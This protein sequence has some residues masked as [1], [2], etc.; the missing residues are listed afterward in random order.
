[1]GSIDSLIRAGWLMPCVRD[2]SLLTARMS[3]GSMPPSDFAGPR[4]VKADVDALN[5]F[6]RLPCAGPR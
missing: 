1:V 6:L 2:G 4:P 3:D 5:A